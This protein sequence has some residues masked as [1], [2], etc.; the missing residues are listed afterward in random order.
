MNAIYEGWFTY[1]PAVEI[2]GPIRLDDCEV[3][4]EDN[5]SPWYEQWCDI[6]GEGGGA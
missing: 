4:D 6:G 5:E 1:H 3:V 2:H